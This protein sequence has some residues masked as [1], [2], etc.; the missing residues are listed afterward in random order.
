MTMRYTKVRLSDASVLADLANLP[1]ALQ[2]ASRAQRLD[3]SW[4]GGTF[5]GVGYYDR[6]EV[7][8]PLAAGQEHGEPVVT[9]STL[10][11]TVTY[12]Y[13][14][15]ALTGDALETAKGDTLAALSEAR[16]RYETGGMVYTRGDGTS[17]GI[18]TD[19]ESQGKLDAE[20][21]AAL[22]GLR[23][24]DDVWKCLDIAAGQ[25]RG[26]A[27]TDAEIVEIANQARAHVAAAFKQEEALAAL[28]RAGDVSVIWVD[29][30]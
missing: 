16:W 17:Y 20:R 28:I 18:T 15:V 27:F 23:A 8:A 6:L 12:D 26:V 30:L 4:L 14:A 5:E 2:G 24:P 7:R 3:A 22:S 25:K 1:P 13:P 19:R 11:G 21:T 10:D 9:V 29:P